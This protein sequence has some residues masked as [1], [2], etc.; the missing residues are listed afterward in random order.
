MS[1]SKTPAALAL[2]L[3][4][5]LIFCAATAQGA[6]IGGTITA[7]LVI[8]NDSKLVD[9]VTCAVTGVPCLDFAASNV[10]L[11]L[12]GFTVTGQA[13]SKTGCS[14]TSAP[15]AEH[16]IRI[17]QQTGVTI[18]G[19]GVVQ[20]HRGHG[21]IINGS[22]GTRIREVTTSRNCASG[23]LVGGASNIL[24]NNISIANGNVVSPCGGI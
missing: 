17:L 11:D 23:I 4:A 3:L 7:T 14:G 1:H 16:G 15:G 5:L 21:I 12:N 9:D 13:D 22:T 19:P 18:R 2:S 24:E 10:T 20:L 6:D 8:S